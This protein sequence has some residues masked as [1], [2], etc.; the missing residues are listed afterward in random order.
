MKPVA[1]LVAD[2]G[3][4]NSFGRN[5]DLR[6]GVHGTLDWIAFDA[7]HRFEDFLCQTGLVSQGIQDCVPLLHNK[8][9]HCISFTMSIYHPSVQRLRQL[10]SEKVFLPSNLS[11]ILTSCLISILRFDWWGLNL[12]QIELKTIYP[13]QDSVELVCKASQRLRSGRWLCWRHSRKIW[14]VDLPDKTLP[15]PILMILT[16]NPLVLFPRLLSNPSTPGSGYCSFLLCTSVLS[17][18]FP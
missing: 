7:W 18:S 5:I 15:V 13:I 4:L 10:I 3:F 8:K 14:P 9:Q 17:I 2:L 11:F 16:A 6:K 12:E 1:H